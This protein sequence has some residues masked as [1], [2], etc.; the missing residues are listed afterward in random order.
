MGQRERE[1]ANQGDEGM[2]SRE[3]HQS[4]RTSQSTPN[5]QKLTLYSIVVSDFIVLTMAR[6]SLNQSAR[7]SSTVHRPPAP[8]TCSFS[9]SCTCRALFPSTLAF[10]DADR[11]LSFSTASAARE[12]DARPSASAAR[13][14]AAERLSCASLCLSARWSLSGV[15]AR[16]GRGKV[17]S[18]D[19]SQ[20]HLN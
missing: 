13:A 8:R 18:S 15:M 9:T 16:T 4:T 2:S 14:S 3:A 12:D 19:S 20:S 7:C 1:G 6:A 5:S 11:Y 17:K 10:L